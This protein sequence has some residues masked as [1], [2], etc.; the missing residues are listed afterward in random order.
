MSRDE[1]NQKLLHELDRSI[2]VD[3]YTR[4]YWLSNYKSLPFSA[5]TMFCEQL[6]IENSK[7]ERLVAAGIDADPAL[8]GKITDKAREIDRKFLRFQE[9]ESRAEEDADRFLKQNL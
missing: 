8:A 1:L 5:V 3:E 2:A 4:R 9:T 7:I 6:T